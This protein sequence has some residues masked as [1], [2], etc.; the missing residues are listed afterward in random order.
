MANPTQVPKV[1]RAV[2][3][4]A[5]IL[6][7][8]K[9]GVVRSFPANTPPE[10]IR[11]Q[12]GIQKKKSDFPILTGETK[13][14]DEAPTK[15]EA[16][17]ILKG[18]NPDAEAKAPKLTLADA[19]ID[20]DA[21]TKEFDEAFNSLRDFYGKT[22][23][24]VMDLVVNPEK[25]GDL[26][27]ATPSQAAFKKEMVALYNK[28]RRVDLYTDKVIAL[29]KPV[30][31]PKRGPKVD[32]E[33][34][35]DFL[36]P[37]REKPAN[38]EQKAIASLVDPVTKTIPWDKG[39]D[40]LRGTSKNTYEKQILDTMAELFA[41]YDAEGFP[42]TTSAKSK[43]DMPTS[44]GTANVLSNP[45]GTAIKHVSALRIFDGMERVT[46][47]HEYT[48]NATLHLIRMYTKGV[49]P[50]NTPVGQTLQ[51]Y[52][53]VTEDLQEDLRLWA[54]TAAGQEDINEVFN[55]LTS[56][57]GPMGLWDLANK[58]EEAVAYAL[59]DPVIY[60]FLKR[61]PVVDRDA[62]I[63]MRSFLNAREDAEAAG[64]SVVAI[65]READELIRVLPTMLSK[66]SNDGKDFFEQSHQVMLARLGVT[67][68][69]IIAYTK[70][71]RKALDDSKVKIRITPMKA[72]ASIIIGGGGLPG[73]LEWKQQ[74]AG[75][76]EKAA[77]LRATP[78]EE[79]STSE[80]MG[81]IEFEF[82]V[83]NA[84]GPIV[85]PF[86]DAGIVELSPYIDNPSGDIT[87]G[88]YRFSED[89][90]TLLSRT[91][92]K[93]WEYDVPLEGTVSA[94]NVNGMTPE[95][96]AHEFGHRGGLNESY[97]ELLGWY[98]LPPR[99]QAELNIAYM[100]TSQWER[101][102]MRSVLEYAGPKL[103]AVEAAAYK[104]SHPGAKGPETTAAFWEGQFRQRMAMWSANIRHPETKEKPIDEE[105]KKYIDKTIEYQ[106]EILLKNIK[107]RAAGKPINGVT[108]LSSLPAHE[109]NAFR[110][111]IDLKT[112]KPYQDPDF[113]RH[114]QYPL[115]RGVIEKAAKE[116]G[117]P[118]AL[119]ATIA[120]R[121]SK[122]DPRADN[123]EDRGLFGINRKAHPDVTDE[124][125]FNPEKAAIWA[126]N[127]YKQML[128]RFKGNHKLALAAYNWGPT[129]LSAHLRKTK[130]KDWLGKL[131]KPVR[132]YVT[133]VHKAIERKPK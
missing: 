104:A 56:A 4:A 44:Y 88:R 39:I 120:S 57:R 99:T 82:E 50:A 54:N 33:A 21:A 117:V 45:D 48:H 28:K 43:T 112:G 12:L 30:V 121:E 2:Q 68:E 32:P 93:L 25:I 86:V 36:H 41:R 3:E 92:E 60:E 105:S 62:K 16:F 84:G 19:E 11:A 76:S 69:D 47:F 100:F 98:R 1:L 115:Y 73:L 108:G 70:S 38:A 91:H 80:A 27:E 87:A 9:D 133:T 10:E 83:S 127:Y 71:W 109:P 49:L 95:V 34:V 58:P 26:S 128:V 126:A 59:S 24:D 51:K 8:D 111:G 15:G 13:V 90:V 14:A 75:A 132:T 35:L 116:T 7:R 122:F 40:Y 65:D 101:N 113:F 37:N 107:K 124:I 67:K 17:P 55:P 22:E 123:G 53:H 20:L 64:R 52:L 89:I 77:E 74:Q 94:K 102:Q 6:V 31:K 66:R 85:T 42:L 96:A 29:S 106:S 81:D 119:L 61:V 103:A 129:K 118:P 79:R 78:K 63:A 130:G 72:L 125:A 110:E 18:L 5:P 131:P 114:P 23:E 97:A 46:L